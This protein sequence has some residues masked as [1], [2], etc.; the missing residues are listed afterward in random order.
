MY[1][2]PVS[3]HSLFC[4]YPICKIRGLDVCFWVFFPSCGLSVCVCSPS[5]GFKKLLSSL[6]TLN[7]SDEG[8]KQSSNLKRS[9]MC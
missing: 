6:P 4:Y 3:Y 2:V 5:S 7:A 9:V 1:S 8:K